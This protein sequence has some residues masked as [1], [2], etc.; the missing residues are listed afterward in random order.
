MLKKV[1]GIIIAS[2]MIL[3]SFAGCSS[4]KESSDTTA[5]ASAST[6]QASSESTKKG[7]VS[8][9]TTISLSFWEGG[10]N[11]EMETALKAVIEEYNKVQPDITVELMSQ[12]NKGYIDWAKAR[13]AA[14]E[15][16]EIMMNQA[17]ELRDQF[18]QGL[19]LDLKDAF[20]SQNPYADG[21]VWKDVFQEGRLE[22]AH[23]YT[24]EP[25]Y[26]VPFSG[27]GIAYFYNK[28]IYEKLGLSVPKTWN[29][30]IANCK[31]IQEA[32]YN[33]VALPAMKK[34]A[35][36]WLSWYIM[37]GLYDDK[38]LPDANL[39]PNGDDYIHPR[40]FVRAVDMGFFDVTKG[41]DQKAYDVYLK[42]LAEYAQYAEG[43]TG[44]DEAGAKA[45]FLAGKAAHL[46]SGSWDMQGFLSGQ[47]SAAKIGAFPLPVFEKSNGEYAGENMTITSVSTMAI[48]GKSVEDENKKKAAV[49]FLMFL[50]APKNY[51][52]FAEK[53]FSIP[54]IKGL[55][56]APEFKA[57][58]E[59]GTREAL[60]IFGKQ[61]SKSKIGNYEITTMILAGEKFNNVNIY[62]EMQKS[63]KEYAVEKMEAWKVSKDTDYG[64]KELGKQGKISISK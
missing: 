6:Q 33:P 2:S 17:S 60:L 24:F 14:N 59:G 63:M 21:T 41:E 54:V 3:A 32:K 43:A 7:L 49:D 46:M 18:Q 50:T 35:I 28:D 47:T 39:N 23:D 9:P 37:T 45:Q 64:V 5:A 27:L 42:F 38:Y 51:K 36:E 4:K 30:F 31:K 40:E 8:A 61:G 16:P 58:S 25:S 62:E 34:D 48:I 22:K 20:G 19:L 55:D 53:S 1:L 15:A 52:I 56:I 44:L 26:A 12:P 13:M 10:T 11:Q 29:E 57:F